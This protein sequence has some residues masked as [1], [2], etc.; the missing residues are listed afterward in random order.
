MS[1][2]QDLSSLRAPFLLRALATF[3]DLGLIAG[4]SIALNSLLN[5]AVGSFFGDQGL[6]LSGPLFLFPITLLYYLYFSSEIVLKRSLGKQLV[7]IEIRTDHGMTPRDEVLLQ[8]YLIKHGWMVF[9]FLG[10]ALNN[11]LLLLVFK[12]W[13]F[14]ISL[15][16]LLALSSKKQSSYDRALKLSVFPIQ[17]PKTDLSMLSKGAEERELAQ[18]AHEQSKQKRRSNSFKMRS[19]EALAK[20]QFPCAVEL[21]V[22]LKGDRD[23]ELLLFECFSQFVPNLHPNQFKASAHARGPYRSCRVVI[24]FDTPLQMETSYAALAALNEVVMTTTIRSVKLEDGKRSSRSLKST[25]SLG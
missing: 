16:A 8:R 2:T 25:H 12:S 4:L 7:G 14:V 22:Y 10:F 23:I 15:L 20:G 6:S 19:K 21:K 5:A 11:E 17:A 9:A 24:R 1:K 13:I 3:V 18:I